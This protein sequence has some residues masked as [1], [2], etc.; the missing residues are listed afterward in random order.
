MPSSYK[1]VLELMNTH[2]CDI[3]A[4]G[5]DVMVKKRNISG[6]APKFK[7][8]TISLFHLGELVYIRSEEDGLHI[9][10]MTR[11]ES[12]LKSELVCAPLKAAIE[13]MASPGIRH[14]ATLGGNIGNA[15]PA[16]DT[17]P[18]LYVYNAKVV[19]ESIEARRILPIEDYIIGPGQTRRNS[20]ELI[21]EIIL[22]HVDYKGFYYEKVG[23][24]RSDAI[25]KL[26][27]I[28]LYN[29]DA[30]NQI[31]DIRLAYGAVY[32]TI[33]RD[34]NLELDLK[35]YMNE[36]EARH[37]ENEL[38]SHLVDIISQNQL[39]EVIKA[40]ELIIQPIDDQRS[41]AKYRK[42]CALNLL[43]SF[44]NMIGGD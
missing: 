21:K 15:S 7:N 5:T 31:S 10:A 32:K 8:E 35:K 14:V 38:L 19:L 39:E 34:K 23:G 36:E 28:G 22:E 44:V 9:G 11:L 27:F 3:L 12:L 43:K 24:R 16:G 40:Y 30:T 25:S 37:K 41:S 29:R 42:L 6:L 33:V 13:Q 17:L 18:I 4:G 1:E 2:L 20:N 26:S